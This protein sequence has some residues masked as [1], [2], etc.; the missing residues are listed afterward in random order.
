[1]SRKKNKELSRLDNQIRALGRSADDYKP[2]LFLNQVGPDRYQYEIN[3]APVKIPLKTLS[4][5]HRIAI[6]NKM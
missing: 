6:L 1:M 5:T 3:Q 2:W 4:K